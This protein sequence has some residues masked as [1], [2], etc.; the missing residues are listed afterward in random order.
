MY[1]FIITLY[2]ITVQ[3]CVSVWHQVEAQYESSSTD[4]V[5]YFIDTNIFYDYLFIIKKIISQKK[6]N[7][8]RI[9]LYTI[10]FN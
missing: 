5:H 7:L 1:I 6:G 8:V 4:T 3:L 2:I 9:E 10:R